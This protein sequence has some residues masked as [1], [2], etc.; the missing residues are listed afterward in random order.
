MR[1]K[2][3]KNLAHSKNEGDNVRF[4]K[5]NPKNPL[6][7]FLNVTWKEIAEAEREGEREMEFELYDILESAKIYGGHFDRLIAQNVEEVLKRE[8]LFREPQGSV[9]I[10]APGSYWECEEERETLKTGKVVASCWYEA[11]FEVFDET[12][13]RIMATG[14]AYGEMM[15][16]YD[17][18]KPEET[19]EGELIDMTVAMPIEDVK[20]LKRHVEGWM[21]IRGRAR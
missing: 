16:Y 4:V 9:I 11:P 7:R 13:N 10:P 21:S 2:I 19:M 3:I 14:V 15:L 5:K 18:Q 17:P 8:G 12:G 1:A 6:S 20:T